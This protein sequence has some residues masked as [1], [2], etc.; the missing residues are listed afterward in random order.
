MFKKIS[1][2]VFAALLVAG[3]GAASA[4]ITLFGHIDTSLDAVD[5]DGGSDDINMNCTTCSIGF[6]G[7]ED[8][9]NGLKAIFK[10][11]FQY[12]TANRNQASSGTNS[13]KDRDQWLGLAGDFGKVRVG[14]I[15]TGY[16]SHGAM[17]D[18]LYR[19]ALQG[20]DSGLQSHF[21]SNAGEELEGRA[22]NTARYDSPD[23]NGMK[24]VAH[25]KVDSNEGQ[26]A[27]NPDENNP[28]GIGAS[29]QNG[30]ILVFADYMDNNQDGLTEKDAWK[31][32]GKYDMGMFSFMGQ[33]EDYSNA[34]SD[35]ETVWHVAGTAGPLFGISAY[36]GFGKG[37]DDTT[38]DDY[39]A[40]TLA[41]MHNMSK[42][43]MIYTGFSQVDCDSGDPD[44]SGSALATLSACSA[45]GSSGGEDDKFSLGLKH[46]F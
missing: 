46:K 8:L 36:L 27:A 33:Y 38:N 26:P 15:S 24:L 35:D 14:T 16:K 6:K 1:Q 25:Y 21:H 32:G 9:G 31:I 23:F 28:F 12:D 41:I 39:T 19:T 13:I 34:A 37:E 30:A 17:I 42:R 7:S 3:T 29:Y 10:L 11:D 20:R 4:D 40:W 18:P 43:T 44:G 2:S 45:V 5:V 22:T